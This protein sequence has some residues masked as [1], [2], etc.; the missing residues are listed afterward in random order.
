MKK[1]VSVMIKVCGLIM[2]MGTLILYILFWGNIFALPMRWLSLLILVLIEVNGIIKMV[3]IKKGIFYIAICIVSFFHCLLAMG[4]ALFFVNIMPLEVKEY[5]LINLLLLMII[6]LIDICF[7]YF[8]EKE[9]RQKHLKGISN[10][11][12]CY[13]KVQRLFLNYQNT[14]YSNELKEV[15]ELL[16]YSNRLW[17]NE[18]ESEIVSKIDKIQEQIILENNSDE[19]RELLKEVSILLKNRTVEL[20]KHGDF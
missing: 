16:K 3:K 15:L 1:N 19:V 6:A 12:E 17:I 8:G 11:D 2:I 13:A 7:L 4:I 5:I 18:N 9:K 20:K 14:E 10:I